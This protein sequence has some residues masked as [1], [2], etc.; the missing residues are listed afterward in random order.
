MKELSKY[1]IVN[2]KKNNSEIFHC[3]FNEI[4]I[5]THYFDKMKDTVSIETKKINNVNK[6]PFP[7]IRSESSFPKNIEDNIR[8][9]SNYL[10]NI[11][12]NIL[13]INFTVHMVYDLN[14]FDISNYIKFII[15][16]LNIAISNTNK[17]CCKNIKIYLYFSNLIKKIPENESKIIDV[18]NANSAYTYCCKTDNEIIIFRKE[19]WLKVFMHETFHTLGLDFCFLD[20]NNISDKI[21]KIFP[22]DIDFGLTEVYCETWAELFNIFFISF[23]NS[24]NTLKTF[25]KT[26]KKLIKY[27]KT[28]SIIQT[29]K[30]LDFMNLDYKDLYCK[31]KVNTYKR[32]TFYKENTNVFSYYI[33][34]SITLFN[35]EEF[36]FWCNDNNLSLLDFYKSNTNI[37]KFINFIESKYKNKTFLNY[38]NDNEDLFKKLNKKTNFYKSMKMSLF[39][40]K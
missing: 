25:L 12:F 14:N 1:K 30:I 29:I 15:V 18:E 37:Q 40:I 22:I 21:K 17:N 4:K 23:F 34:K 36:I 8:K 3:V 39:E 27:E 38:I 13:G 20:N 6:I 31:D 28:F 35:L 11:E 19:E 7:K 33:L 26:T 10:S 2:N 5:A 16:W 24:N 32:E 9:N